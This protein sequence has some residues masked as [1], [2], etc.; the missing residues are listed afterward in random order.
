[1]S[2]LESLA[3]SRRN[4]E[5]LRERLEDARSRKVVF[6]SHCLLNENTRYLGGACRRCCVREV[7]EQCMDLG[8]GMVQM[9]CPEQEVW[10]GV[11]KKRLLALYGA[12][13]SRLV[14]ALLPIGLRYVRWAY[15]R[16]A[17]KVAAQIED[18]VTSGYSV[19]G[20]IGVDGSPTCGVHKTIDIRSFVD[21]MSRV[22]PALFT[23]Q[24]QNDL[25]VRH[26][27][28]GQGLFVAQLERELDARGLRVP[29]LAHDLLR[30]LQA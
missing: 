28:D 4:V 22:D 5:V 16:L 23:V 1:M 13:R 7:I 24:A 26:A 30:E 29:V 10:G 19:L 3:G 20:V 21:D 18:Y 11:L 6:L 25:V 8:I 9:P 2:L 14:G 15:R 17:R 12:K 27:T